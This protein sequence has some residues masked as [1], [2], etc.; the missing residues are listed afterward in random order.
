LPYLPVI[1]VLWTCA[2]EE[3]SYLAV[4]LDF[5][6]GYFDPHHVKWIP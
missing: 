5:G 1:A 4:L 3:T 2:N 6:H